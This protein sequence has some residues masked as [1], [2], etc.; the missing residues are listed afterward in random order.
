MEILHRIPASAG[1]QG[2]L[3]PGKRLED[4]LKSDG[5]RVGGD[6]IGA[7][8]LGEWEEGAGGWRRS[9]DSESAP[10][11]LYTSLQLLQLFLLTNYNLH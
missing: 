9:E 11:F 6:S 8:V 5:G 4:G 1:T 3:N 2:S 7:C 10:Y